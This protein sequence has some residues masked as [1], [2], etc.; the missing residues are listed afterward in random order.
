MH[1]DHQNREQNNNSN[2][3]FHWPATVLKSK[4]IINLYAMCGIV[5]NE[6]IV[7]DESF[8]ETIFFWSINRGANH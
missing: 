1:I 7:Y 8:P 3:Q 5:F 4:W 2:E 6:S